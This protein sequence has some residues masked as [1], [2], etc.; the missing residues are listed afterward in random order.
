MYTLAVFFCKYAVFF[1]SEEEPLRDVWAAYTT[2]YRPTPFAR[3]IPSV[4]LSCLSVTSRNT[5]LENGET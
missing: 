2:V 5:E 4:C 3:P 1:R